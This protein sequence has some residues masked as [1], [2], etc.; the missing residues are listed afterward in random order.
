MININSSDVFYSGK[1][2]IKLI[3]DKPYK[4]VR[5][6]NKSTGFFHKYIL[7]TLTGHYSI[8]DMIYGVR[9]VAELGKEP[10]YLYDDLFPGAPLFGEAKVYEAS[11]DGDSDSYYITYNFLIPQTFTLGNSIAGIELCNRKKEV[12]ARVSTT[13]DNGD[14]LILD[15]G[16]NLDITWSLIISSGEDAIEKSESDMEE[17]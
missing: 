2:E 13:D 1:V 6:H 17:I 4:L 10:K 8:D 15:A 16:S 9:L 12:Y 3:K 11:V 7:E 5:K 14:N